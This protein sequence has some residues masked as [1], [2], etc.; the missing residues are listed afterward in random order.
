M[1]ILLHF[2]TGHSA[3]RLELLLDAV[4]HAADDRTR[5]DAGSGQHAAHHYKVRAKCERLHNIAGCADAAISN[6]RAVHARALLHRGEIGH[7]KAG[8]HARGA[9]RAAANAHLDHIRAA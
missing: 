7:A 6:Q 8:L 5:R 2:C 1:E 3:V 4:N 9:H